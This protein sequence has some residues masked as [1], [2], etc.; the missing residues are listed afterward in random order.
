MKKLIC[1]LGLSLL[2]AL[3]ATADST[4]L[5][6]LIDVSGSMKANDPNSL[7][8]PAAELIA[9]LL[10]ANSRAGAWLF[11]TQTRS[12]VDYGDVEDQSVFG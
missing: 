7:R 1:A 2:T 6:V 5:R 4:D 11:G 8:G 10:P 12:L 3:P 9:R